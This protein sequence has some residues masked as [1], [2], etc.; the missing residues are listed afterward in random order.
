[1]NINTH[2][3]TDR[4]ISGNVWAALPA[5]ADRLFLHA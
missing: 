1:M 4:E 2:N 5:G 3:S